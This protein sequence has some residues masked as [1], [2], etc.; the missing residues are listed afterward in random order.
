MFLQEIVSITRMSKSICQIA[1]IGQQD[2]T[3]A[4]KIQPPYRI[5][6]TEN[7]HETSHIFSIVTMFIFNR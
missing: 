4:L 1:I 3:F 6:M 7:I 5:D 2:Q